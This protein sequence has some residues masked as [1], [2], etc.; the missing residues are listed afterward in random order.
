MNI[1]DKITDY[2]NENKIDDFVNKFK[3]KMGKDTTEQT[4]KGWVDGIGELSK[5][6]KKKLLGKILN[7]IEA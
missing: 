1:T 3:N 7:Y 6:D 5:S 2:L 4:A